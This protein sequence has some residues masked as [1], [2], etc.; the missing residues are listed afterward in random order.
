[1]QLALTE[2]ITGVLALVR[3]LGAGPW[4]S[5]DV[6]QQVWATVRVDLNA[7]TGQLDSRRLRLHSA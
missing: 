2:G 5:F 7:D 1:M 4:A 6:G 3:Q